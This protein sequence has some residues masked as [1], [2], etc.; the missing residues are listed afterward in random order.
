MLID[1]VHGVH[2]QLL[3]AGIIWT[4]AVVFMI[5][6]IIYMENVKIKEKVAITDKLMN[7]RRV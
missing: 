3:W 7:N 6:N 5:A 4:T 1:S 2:L